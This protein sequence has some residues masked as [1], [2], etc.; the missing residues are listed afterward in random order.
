MDSRI[1][2]TGNLSAADELK[3]ILADVEA[4]GIGSGD[5]G[6]R[7]DEATEK[8]EVHLD[9][10]GSPFKDSAEFAV[11]N[12]E[13]KIALLEKEK[14]KVMVDCEQLESTL[15]SR[16]MNV[17][18]ND[19]IHMREP[20][21]SATLESNAAEARALCAE[22]QVRSLLRE[23]DA[24]KKE[25][26]GHADARRRAELK[27]AKLETSLRAARFETG[28]EEHA[29]PPSFARGTRASIL[30]AKVQRAKAAA[31]KSGRG[32]RQDHRL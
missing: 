1:G 21:S 19:R 23:V 15:S 3:K 4:L 6:A 7:I 13:R 12:L 20:H 32:V 31:H 17:S 29:A 16:S 8:I 28:R 9:T 10:T 30:R 5:M 18:S 2:D 27:S 14:D 24:L 22:Q 11:R 26:R 25:G